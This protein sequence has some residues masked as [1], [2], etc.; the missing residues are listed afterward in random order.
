VH[1][2]VIL[3]LNAPSYR[4]EQAQRGQPPTPAG[5]SSEE[6]PTPGTERPLAQP[7]KTQGGNVG[8]Q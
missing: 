5:P 1:H 4:L 3:E 6:A 2:S 7:N 8:Q